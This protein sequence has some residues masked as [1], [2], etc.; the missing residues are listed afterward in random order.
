ML[1]R[2]GRPFVQ[3][4]FGP[5]AK[6]FVKMGVSADAVTLAGAV[7]GVALSLTLL[8]TNHLVVGSLSLGGLALFDS[9]DGQIARL[10]NTSSKWGAFLDSTLDRIT[11]VAIF[12]GLL[13]WAYLHGESGAMRTFLM[14]GLLAAMG[15]GSVVPYARARAE[16]LGMT[17]SVGIAER[18]DRLVIILFSALFVGLGL[19]QWIL[20]ASAWYLTAAG[21]VTVVQRM[22]V[23]YRQARETAE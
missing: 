7:L 9:I 10:T 14:I 1:S 20:L 19:P 22:A 12:S 11:D 8:P 3:T 23:V 18:A 15:T 2:T 21:L 5:I 13:A 17:A 16:G 6:L 4:V